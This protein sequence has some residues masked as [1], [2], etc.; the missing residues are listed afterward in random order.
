MPQCESAA[1]AERLHAL[2]LAL[3]T[4]STATATPGQW[5]CCS[6]IQALPEHLL[7]TSG[8]SRYGPANTSWLVKAFRSRM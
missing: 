4:P 5:H 1:R 7:L 8:S 3:V 2:A 6:L